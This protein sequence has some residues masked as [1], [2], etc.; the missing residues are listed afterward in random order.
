VW[1][2]AVGESLFEHV[3]RLEDE[4]KGMRLRLMTMMSGVGRIIVLL[5]LL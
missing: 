2:V 1:D 3:R 4:L 5:V